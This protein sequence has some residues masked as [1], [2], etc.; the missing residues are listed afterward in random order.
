MDY[1][2]I[3]NKMVDVKILL[4]KCMYAEKWLAREMRI[5]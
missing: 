1:I 4:Y 5:L 2:N 3:Y